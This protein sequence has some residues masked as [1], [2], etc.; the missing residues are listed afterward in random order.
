MRVFS[1]LNALSPPPLLSV[2]LDTRSNWRDMQIDLKL[3]LHVVYTRNL[4]IKSIKI[5]L[6]EYAREIFPIL[7]ANER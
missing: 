2:V 4:W 7:R 6:R 3:N 1:D 5:K